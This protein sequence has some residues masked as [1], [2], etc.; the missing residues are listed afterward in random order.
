MSTAASVRGLRTLAVRKAQVTYPTGN[1][2]FA[3]LQAF[4]AAF[5]EQE[6]GA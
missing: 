5:S 3:V 1:K 4:P 6:C 2:S